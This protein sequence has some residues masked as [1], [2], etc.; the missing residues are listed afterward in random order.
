MFHGDSSLASSPP[1]GIDTPLPDECN[2]EVVVQTSMLI[3]KSNLDQ[4]EIPNCSPKILNPKPESFKCSRKT[5]DMDFIAP[6]TAPSTSAVITNTDTTVSP[7]RIS[8]SLLIPSSA[9]S[10]SNILENS[11]ESDRYVSAVLITDSPVSSPS[12]SPQR[13]SWLD[14]TRDYDGEIT[15]FETL[16]SDSGNSFIDPDLTLNDMYQN[17]HEYICEI[18]SKSNPYSLEMDHLLRQNRTFAEYEDSQDS[19]ASVSPD[20]ESFKHERETPDHREFIKSPLEAS[21]NVFI[22][23]IGLEASRPPTRK[24]SAETIPENSLSFS[25][26]CKTMTRL[27]N[28]DNQSSSP[29][30][31]NTSPTRSSPFRNLASMF[32]TTRRNPTRGARW[33]QSYN[34][35]HFNPGVTEV[36]LEEVKLEEIPNQKIAT[37]AP[38]GRGRPRGSFSARIVP[39]NKQAVAS[40]TT[41]ISEKSESITDKKRVYIDT[42][43][44]GKKK[45]MVIFKINDPKP[46]YEV[47]QESSKGK[48][49]W[50]VKEMKLSEDDTITKKYPSE[51]FQLVFNKVSGKK[52]PLDSEIDIHNTITTIQTN[53]ETSSSEEEE[54]KEEYADTSASEDVYS[55]DYEEQNENVNHVEN[56]NAKPLSISASSSNV[57]VSPRKGPKRK[58]CPPDEGIISPIKHRRWHNEQDRKIIHL[59]ET[60][61]WPWRAIQ[62]TLGTNHS[63]Q[64]IQMRYLRSL[65]GRWDLW[66]EEEE[67]K[68]LKAFQRDWTKRWNRISSEMGPAFPEER[69]LRKVYELAGLEVCQEQLYFHTRAAD[70]AN[71]EEVDSS[72]CEDYVRLYLT[73]I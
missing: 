29:H 69:C 46:N 49:I 57:L 51:N 63:W 13:K 21:K 31:G 68:L 62:Q 12:S 23:N 17:Q 55:S 53:T 22:K 24:S 42:T 36:K 11:L 26:S 34:L 52:L 41:M 9:Y 27:K 72:N 59:K 54:L 64:A 32:D 4:E 15:L 38:R 71:P 45:F 19:S 47:Q 33:E 6:N 35:K 61:N 10:N 50:P 7:F 65:K 56:S 2:K 5:D 58:L 30:N 1:L 28:K 73:S 60:L 14:Y 37:G 48:K 44:P 67:L 43:T 16:N 18:P 20:N 25:Q 3:S 40:T 70:E 39:T 8:Q 66:T